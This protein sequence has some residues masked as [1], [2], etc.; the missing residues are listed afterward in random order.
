MFTVS[1][2]GGRI[3]TGWRTALRLTFRYLSF[4]NLYSTFNPALVIM[5]T[6]DSSENISMFEDRDARH[7]QQS[8]FPAACAVPA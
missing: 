2:R 1:G 7:R 4:L 3:R 5:P 8:I 6:K